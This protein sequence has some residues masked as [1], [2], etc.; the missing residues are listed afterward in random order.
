MLSLDYYIFIESRIFWLVTTV[1]QVLT[2]ISWPY[3]LFHSNIPANLSWSQSRQA[4]TTGLSTS[5]KQPSRIP[6]SMSKSSQTTTKTSTMPWA[7]KW[8]LSRPRPTTSSTPTITTRPGQ[9]ICLP[10]LMR[11]SKRR[12]SSWKRR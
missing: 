7:P 8:N 12:W 5:P 3:H 10:P 4:M 9:R 11:P 6:S 1:S 2:Q